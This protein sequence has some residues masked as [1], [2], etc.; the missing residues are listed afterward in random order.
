[1]LGYQWIRGGIDIG[2]YIGVDYQDYDLSPDDSTSD[3]RGDEVGF[4]VALD[5]E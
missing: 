4:K 3:L 2:A 1:M 5:I